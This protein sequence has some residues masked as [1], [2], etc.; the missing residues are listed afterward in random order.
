MTTTSQAS[1]HPT[2][3]RPDET[4][5]RALADWLGRH[6][7]PCPACG[8]NLRSVPSPACPECGAPLRLM[9]GS[10]QARLGPWLL[11]LASFL[12]ALGFDSVATLLLTIPAIVS[13]FLP[14]GPPM[15]YFMVLGLM[16]ALSAGTGAAAWATIARRRGWP[17]W[18]RRTQWIVAGLIFAGV[19]VTH[20]A[21]G[22]LAVL[23]MN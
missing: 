21:A 10:E 18:S 19:G 3:G 14:G 4:D 16:T 22:G 12:L 5:G 17:R 7:E 8:H 23:W 6:D 9:V 13:L 1:E 2:L 15:P 20:L 11:A